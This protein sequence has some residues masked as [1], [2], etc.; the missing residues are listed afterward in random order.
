MVNYRLIPL[1]LTEIESD[2]YKTFS[3]A[4]DRLRIAVVA[5]EKLLQI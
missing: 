3:E 5:I 2:L 4:V 1:S